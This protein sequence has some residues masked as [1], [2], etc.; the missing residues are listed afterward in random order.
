MIS[1]LAPQPLTRWIRPE[2][3]VD[4]LAGSNVEGVLRALAEVLAADLGDTPPLEI[5][6]RLLERERLGSTGGG[7]GFAMPHCRLASVAQVHVFV[8]RSA[9]EVDFAALDRVP[10]RVFFAIATPAGPAG[11]HLQV[12]AAIARWLKDEERSRRLLAAF[13]RE[14]MVALL[15]EVV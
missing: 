5:F 9:D 3:V 7:R 4:G 8:A 11:L 12:L 2:R 1:Q 10:V 13:D 6:A 15:S 14:T